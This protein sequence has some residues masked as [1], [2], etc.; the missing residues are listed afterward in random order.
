MRLPATNRRPFV[1]CVTNVPGDETCWEVRTAA[2]SNSDRDNLSLPCCSLPRVRL[3]RVLITDF[4]KPDIHDIAHQTTP[5]SGAMASFPIGG[6][7]PGAVVAFRAA[8]RS[9]VR[10]AP[11]AI[12]LCLRSV[13][14]GQNSVARGALVCTARRK[15][16]IIR[17]CMKDPQLE[18]RM[19][20]CAP[21]VRKT[22]A[23]PPRRRAALP[24]Q[25]SARRR[26]MAERSGPLWV[27]M[28]VGLEPWP[29]VQ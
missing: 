20:G 13:V 9:Y 14:A 4:L 23:R 26:A 6:R 17:H 19:A 10:T 21:P 5:T 12:F 28:W 1:R 3:V 2:G 11:A 16:G 22:C 15:R 27:D 29:I 8:R 25:G 7:D 24:Y 18:G